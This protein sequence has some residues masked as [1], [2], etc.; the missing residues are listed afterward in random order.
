L[1]EI[2]NTSYRAPFTRRLLLGALP[3]ASAALVRADSVGGT[4]DASQTESVIGLKF[5][6]RNSVRIGV[7]GTGGRGTGLTDNLLSVGNVRINALCDTNRDHAAQAANLVEKAGGGVPA[8]YTGGEHDFER[9][10]GRDDLDLIVIATPWHW[11]V[12]MAVYAM[13]HGKHVAVEVPAA[14]T[15]EDCWKLVRT[16]E[17]TRRHCIM[18]ENCCYGYN[19]MLVLNM[20]RAGRLGALTHGAGGYLHNLT[21]KLTSETEQPWLRDEYIRRNGNLYPTHGLGP[22]AMYMGIHRGDRFDNLVSYSSPSRGL[23]ESQSRRAAPRAGKPLAGFRCGDQN[24][25][26]IRTAHGLLISLEH[27]VSTPEPYDRINLIAGSRGIFRDFPPRIY[28]DGETPDDAWESLDRYKPE[29]GRASC[30]ERV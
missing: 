26:L 18:L 25:S 30:R 7:I 23:T 28:L 22:V 6:S 21:G 4:A 29:I 15:I 14:T 13:R 17:Q 12:P 24:T 27:N 10:C 2:T 8:L 1:S 16:S 11:H 20:V 19:E 5:Q 9:L 3:L